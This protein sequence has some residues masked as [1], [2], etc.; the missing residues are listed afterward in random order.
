MTATLDQQL[1]DLCDIH[2]LTAISI[3]A[4]NAPHGRFFSVNVHAGAGLIGNAIGGKRG[5]ADLFKA[6]LLDLRAKQTITMPELAPLE[7]VAAHEAGRT[8]PDP[9]FEGDEQ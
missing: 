2:G 3:A 6:A 9:F 7:V 5:V 1:Q 4:N 8:D